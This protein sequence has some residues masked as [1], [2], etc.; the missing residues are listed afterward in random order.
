MSIKKKISFYYLIIIE[1]S[2]EGRLNKKKFCV[3][4]FYIYVIKVNKMPYNKKMAAAHILV[5]GRVQGVF[6]RASTRDTALRHHLTGWVRN[7]TD[8]RVEAMLEGEKESIEKVIYWCQ[9]G[10]PA[11]APSALEI[12][13][14]E[15]SGS[16]SD[17]EV[18][19]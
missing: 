13:W 19:Y 2:K 6:Y 3:K 10:P 12:K 15:Y 16:F 17:F 18:L 4:I 5:S 11:S 1:L 9:K 7:L 14:L 8:G